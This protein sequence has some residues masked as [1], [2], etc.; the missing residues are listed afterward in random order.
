MNND[1]VHRNAICEP[2]TAGFLPCLPIIVFIISLPPFCKM[3]ANDFT[4]SLY[5]PHRFGRFAAVGLIHN[6]RK[7]IDANRIINHRILPVINNITDFPPEL[8]IHGF[9]QHT[10]EYAVIHTN[11]VGFQQFHHPVPSFVIHNVVCYNYE[12]FLGAYSLYHFAI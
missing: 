7:A 11:S 1:Y 5:H 4:A 3:F 10:F 6:L 8:S 2:F 12:Q 9:R